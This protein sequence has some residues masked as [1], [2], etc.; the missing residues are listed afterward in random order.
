M[1]L[2]MSE[3]MLLQ[4]NCVALFA[5][6][7]VSRNE[8]DRKAVVSKMVEHPKKYRNLESNNNSNSE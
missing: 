6:G 5:D 4:E 1:K 3:L 2:H 7:N 8:Q